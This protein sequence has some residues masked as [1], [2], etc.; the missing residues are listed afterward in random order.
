MPAVRRGG[1]RITIVD[2]YRK[3]EMAREA[4]EV[5]MAAHEQGNNN[6]EGTV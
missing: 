2:M 1:E 3:S 6:E 4:P 5:Q